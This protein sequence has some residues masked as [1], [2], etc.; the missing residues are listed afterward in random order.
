VAPYVPGQDTFTRWADPGKLKAYLAAGLPIVVTDVPPNA[1]ELARE[2]GGEVVPY[3]AASLAE[4]ISRA[5][6]SPEVWRARRQAALGYVRRFDWEL[7]LSDLLAKLDL[8]L[9]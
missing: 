7:L 2:A 8:G 4:A 3:D 6:A 5:L 9:P 1:G